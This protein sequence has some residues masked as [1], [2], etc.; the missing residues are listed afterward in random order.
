MKT[1]I[2]LLVLLA[3]MCSLIILKAGSQNYFEGSYLSASQKAARENKILILNF[4]TRWCQPCKFIET[5][6]YANQKVQ[7]YAASKAI[8]FKIDIDDAE[9]KS[10]KKEF[11]IVSLPTTIVIHPNGHIIARKEESMTADIFIAWMS[12]TLEKNGLAQAQL[13]ILSTETITK[14]IISQEEDNTKIVINNKDQDKAEK[15]VSD[16]ILAEDK[17][18]EV[19]K[20]EVVYTLQTGVFSNE[21]NA[22]TY[23]IS[24]KEKFNHSVEAIKWMNENGSILYKI[25]LGQFETLEEAELF[26]DYLFNSGI[27]GF[28]CER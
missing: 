20:N 23:V 6:V 16:E 25:Y 24:L 12:E 9:G 14:K 17:F 15:I 28:I 2:V 21:E 4:N 19:M 11:K 1:R 13:P 8:F 7:T 3:I 18:K 27:T 22:K 10:F 5:E 26:K